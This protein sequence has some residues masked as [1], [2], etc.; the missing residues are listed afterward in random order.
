M[1]NVDVKIGQRVAAARGCVGM[2]QRDLASLTGLSQPTIHRI[3]VGEREASTLELAVIADACGVLVADLLGTNRLS[4]E[5]LCAGRTDDE[6]S[7][8]LSDYLEYAF[9]LWRR[10]DEIGVPEVA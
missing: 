6:G 10:L 8:A 9:G 5:V 4:D 7:K 3:E 2:T 1:S